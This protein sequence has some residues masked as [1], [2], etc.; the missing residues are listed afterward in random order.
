MRANLGAGGAGWLG[1]SL[2]WSVKGGAGRGR[3]GRRGRRARSRS[4]SRSR[5]LEQQRPP[6]SRGGGKGRP[7]LP[8]GS[9]RPHLRAARKKSEASE[10]GYSG[11][12]RFTRGSPRPRLDRRRLR[13]ESERWGGC[14]KARSLA[15]ERILT[16]VAGSSTRSIQDYH[17]DYTDYAD[18][19]DCPDYALLAEFHRADL[20]FQALSY[21]QGPC[22]FQSLAA[23]SCCWQQLLPCRLPL[24]SF[25]RV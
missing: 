16:E 3:R 20:R 15:S 6:A 18:C 10:V 24:S 25:F 8:S 23:L 4:R 13:A 9:P 1:G 22:V 2:P 7:F 12:T 5:H 17:T 14:G 11:S 19:T 21:G